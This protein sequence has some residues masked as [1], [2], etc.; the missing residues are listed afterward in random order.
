VV[1]AP[2]PTSSEPSNSSSKPLSKGLEKG[3]FASF[4]LET[5]QVNVEDIVILLIVATSA[6]VTVVIGVGCFERV[7]CKLCLA[8]DRLLKLELHLGTSVILEKIK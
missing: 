2:I 4:I 6:L 8:L 1:G 3:V 5:I 7:L